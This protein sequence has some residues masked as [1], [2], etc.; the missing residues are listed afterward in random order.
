MFKKLKI[1]FIATTMILLTSIVF[2]IMIAI[3]IGMKSNSEYE[4]FSRLGDSLNT[5]NMRP[6]NMDGPMDREALNSIIGKYNT[7]NNKF[8]YQTKLDI[9]ESELIKTIKEVLSSNKNKGF[10]E[11]DDYTFAYIYKQNPAGDI[12]IILREESS[13]KQFLNRLIIISSI[14][15]AISLIVFFFISLIIAKKAIRP[16]EEA[17]NSQ[18]R[19]IADASHELKT[20]LAIISTNIDLLN[21][22]ENDT[23]KNQKKWIDYI[24]FQTNRMSKLVS[25]LLYL[26]KA[27]NN[28][29]LGEETEFNLSDI[30]MNQ[31][32]NFEGILYEN[33]LELNCDI[34]E[35]ILF[36]GNK[37]GFNQ[38]IGI[39]IDNA[40]KHSFKN[41]EIKISL[42]EDKQKIH[43]SVENTGENIPKEDLEKIFERFYRVDKSRAREKG[44]YGLGL[45]I[46]KTI[47]SKYNG[48]IYAESEN[49]RTIF[50]VDL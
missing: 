10:T 15:G 28:E 5:M 47:V 21:A 16:V 32:L 17:Y 36:K 14:I 18:K 31:A 40:I 44:G 4:I 34:K 7:A 3:Y 22:N 30:V 50:H 20:P 38:L 48:K 49:N 33:N 41:T 42:K 6:N 27:D 24:A 39:L 8:I 2:L 11:S 26:A 29:V 46:A 35:N 19:F 45:S 23:I 43:L 1:R 12:S 25:N 37:E 13:H 9:E